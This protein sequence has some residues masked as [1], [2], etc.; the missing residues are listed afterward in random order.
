VLRDDFTEGMDWQESKL[1]DIMLT[2]ATLHE[3]AIVARAKRG[4]KSD[5]LPEILVV[6][7]DRM[8]RSAEARSNT[9]FGRSA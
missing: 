4:A 5:H 6:E 7:R 1:G 9:R 3:L 2:E 8:F